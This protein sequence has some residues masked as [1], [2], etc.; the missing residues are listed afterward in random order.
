MRRALSLTL[1]G[2]SSGCMSLMADAQAGAVASTR[3]EEGRYGV[4]AQVAGGAALSE[5]RA[6]EHLGPGADLRVKVTRDIQ[7]VGI[8]PHAYLLATSWT[9]PYARIGSTL[10]EVGSV[11]G[12]LSVG[13]LGPRAEIGAF[14]DWFVLSAFAEYDLRWTRQP[15]EGFF[16][17]T[18]GVGEA[19]STAPLHRD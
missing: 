17:L 13:A 15:H 3:L 7:Q 18:V 9:T 11:D 6:T 19:M 8:G 2:L 12:D 10:I 4:A 1:A 16:G 14:F 5:S